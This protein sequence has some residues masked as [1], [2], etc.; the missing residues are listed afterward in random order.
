M[1]VEISSDGCK[2]F[3]ADNE[4]P[5]IDVVRTCRARNRDLTRRKSENEQV[6]KLY[7][8]RPSHVETQKS[9]L[10]NISSEHP[11]I[12]DDANRL[13]NIEE[14][15]IRADT[16]LIERFTEARLKIMMGLY[17]RKAEESQNM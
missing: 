10:E 16:G 15:E 9:A 13:W 1:I 17:R 12:F 7:A 2:S 14:S 8:Q 5:S 4:F 6:C 3:Q 11:S